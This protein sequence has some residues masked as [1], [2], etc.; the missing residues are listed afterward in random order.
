LLNPAGVGATGAVET[1][2]PNR[3]GGGPNSSGRARSTVTGRPT[4][5][6]ARRLQAN[7]GSGR[8]RVREREV[9]S[10]Q[11]TNKGEGVAACSGGHLRRES[12]GV[13]QGS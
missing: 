6:R 8:T 5:S 3:R 7:L 9:G 12:D 1:A 4:C 11:R 13:E 2:P 10:F